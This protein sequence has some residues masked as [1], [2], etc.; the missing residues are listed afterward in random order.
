MLTAGDYLAVSHPQM[1]HC[2]RNVLF[3]FGLRTVDGEVLCDLDLGE[4]EMGR[5][6]VALPHVSVDCST[7]Y[8]FIFKND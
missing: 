3:A 6:V 1:P 8:F 2:V 4:E 7:F 5:L